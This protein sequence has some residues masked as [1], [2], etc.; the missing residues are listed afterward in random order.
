MF[1][2]RYYQ[3]QA[4]YVKRLPTY[5][6]AP[7]PVNVMLFDKTLLQALYTNKPFALNNFKDYTL[8]SKTTDPVDQSTLHQL[9]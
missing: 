2:N 3:Q 7:L 9:E 6:Q 8:Y 5:L 1:V 4:D